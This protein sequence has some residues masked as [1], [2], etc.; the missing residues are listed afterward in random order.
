MDSTKSGR[1]TYFRRYYQSRKALK[2]AQE[3]DPLPSDWIDC[4]P[5]RPGR[6]MRST[7]VNIRIHRFEEP[8][9]PFAHDFKSNGTSSPD[10][11]ASS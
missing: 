11:C 9:D 6:P 7:A 8:V 10:P 5:G 2:Q 1:A 4:T 3:E